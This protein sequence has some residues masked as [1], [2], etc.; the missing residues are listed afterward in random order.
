LLAFAS[1]FSA[2][3]FVT[4]T[5]SV[6]LWLVQENDYSPEA[7]I[8]G[9]SLSAFAF[10]GGLGSILGGFLAP[11]LGPVLTIVGALLATL[12]PLLTVIASEPGTAFYFGAIVLAGVLL[13]VPVPALIIIAQEFVP[14]APATAAGMVLGLGSALAGVS[15]VVLGR[16]QEA[17]GLTTGILIGFSMVVPSGLIALVVLL[18]GSGETP[19]PAPAQQR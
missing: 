10:S 5:G 16:V 4:F 18:R 17:V 15:Y 9:W 8:I 13:F 1:M 11:R 3:A 7:A 14:G 12:F 19:A 6:P 2:L